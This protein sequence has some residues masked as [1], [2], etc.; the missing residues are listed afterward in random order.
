MENERTKKVFRVF[1]NSL[2]WIIMTALLT[3]V[4]GWDQAGGGGRLCKVRP[5]PPP[6]LPKVPR[7]DTW[8]ARFHQ[9]TFSGDS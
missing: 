6:L 3:Q 9:A 8:Q 1:A 7:T 4:D 2:V 5:L